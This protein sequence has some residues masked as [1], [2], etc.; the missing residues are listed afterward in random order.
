MLLFSYFCHVSVSSR[1]LPVP[2][3]SLT[4][5]LD[6]A[7]FASHLKSMEFE[8]K[9][10]S[11]CIDLIPNVAPTLPQLLLLFVCVCVG[12]GWGGAGEGGAL[13]LN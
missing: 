7:N 2:Q 4:A 10:Q 5:V 11:L 8:L 9:E 3:K 13:T 6:K 1:F 12:V